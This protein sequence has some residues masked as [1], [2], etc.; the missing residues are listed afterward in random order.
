M[1]YGLGKVLWIGTDGTWR[2]RHRVGD[3]YHHRFW[4]QAVRWAASGKLAAGNRLV[5]FGPD[6]PKIDDG[7]SARL[8]ARFADDA[9]GVNPSLLVAA[10]VFKASRDQK[11]PTSASIEGEAVAVVPLRP[12][13][14]EPRAFEGPAPPLPPGR[15]VIRLNVPQLADALKAEG[16]PPEAIWRSP[17]ARPPN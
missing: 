7:E 3:A 1:P 13:L 6:R 8:R 5:R 15:Y 14:G 17:P 11:T 16:P 4:G 9:P 2:W 12:K 10:R